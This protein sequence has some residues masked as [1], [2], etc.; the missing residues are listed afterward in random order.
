MNEEKDTAALVADESAET[1][2]DGGAIE[3]SALL[4]HRP[5]MVLIDGV[6]RFDLESR[7]LVASFKVTPDSPFFDVGIDGVPAW[8]A[9]E[10]M[11][12]TSAALAGRYDLTVSSDSPPKPGLLLGTRRLTLGVS[13][14]A[15]GETYHVRA[16]NEYSDSDAAAFNCTIL[17]GDGKVAA[18]GTLNAYRPPDFGAFLDSAI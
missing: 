15:N 13:R 11:A 1:A 14:F 8:A 12:Q 17:D 5:P 7:S 3:L 6:E 2:L 10:Y 18:T 9:I 16:V 4:P